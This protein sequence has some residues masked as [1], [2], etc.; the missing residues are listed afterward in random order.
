MALVQL[1]ATWRGPSAAGSRD[2]DRTPGPS[3]GDVMKRAGTCTFVPLEV[4][5]RRQA[6]NI[7]RNTTTATGHAAIVPSRGHRSCRVRV[8]VPAGA[9][10][11]VDDV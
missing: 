2:V 5:G 8:S 1:G 3:L 11:R 7:K 6:R 4:A 10:S 9:R